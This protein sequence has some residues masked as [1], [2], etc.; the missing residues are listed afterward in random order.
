MAI[1]RGKPL[2]TLER[3]P[4]TAE[5]RMVDYTMDFVFAVEDKLK[6]LGMSRKELADRVGCSKSQ[7]S[8]TLSGANITLKTMAAYDEALGLNLRIKPA[9][10]WTTPRSAPKAFVR[11]TE[12]I[13]KLY[14]VRSCASTCLYTK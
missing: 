8:R 7:V 5:S 6:K 3:A 2:S 12:A 4:E 9:G 14:F 1:R 11:S 13:I 10:E